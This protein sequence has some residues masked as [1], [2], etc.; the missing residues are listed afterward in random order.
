MRLSIQQINAFI[1]NDHILKD[2][3]FDAHNNETLAIIGPSGAGKT[4]LL[5]CVAGLQKHT[6]SVS[7]DGAVIDSTPTH[8]R[9]I[10]MVTQEMS[11]FPHLTVLENVAFP[12]MMRGRGSIYAAP[13]EDAKRMLNQFSITHLTD[14]YP[15]QIS[16][17]EQQRVA[18]AQALVYEPQLLLLD[19]P[20]GSLDASIH[21]D[22]LHWLKELLHKRQTTTLFV[23]HDIREAKFLCDRVV[24]LAD[25]TVAGFGAFAEIAASKN[26]KIQTFFKKML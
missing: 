3:G 13:T 14:R 25:G 4:T 6:G 22:L 15:H 5:R 18:L 2:V 7:F 24:F 16:G 8:R 26:Q 1:N 20:F 21:Y 17:G 11:L 12:L 9:N 19:E 23:T 10:G